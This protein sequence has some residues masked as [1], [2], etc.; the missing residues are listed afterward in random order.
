MKAVALALALS[1]LSGAA[2]AQENPV[3]REA[4]DPTGLFIAKIEA[5]LWYE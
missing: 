4:S 3:Q 5:R 2:G 1:L